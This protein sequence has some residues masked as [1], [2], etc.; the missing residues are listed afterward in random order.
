MNFYHLP[1]DQGL[2]PAFVSGESKISLLFSAA[3]VKLYVQKQLIN[4]KNN[5]ENMIKNFFMISHFI[6]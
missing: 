6:C 4:N 2:V 3:F 1:F 5:I